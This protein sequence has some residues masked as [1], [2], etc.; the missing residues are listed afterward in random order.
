MTP[1]VVITG[2]GAVTPLGVGVDAL[3]GRWS[4]GECSVEDGFARC[5]DL[6]LP[7][8]RIAMPNRGASGSTDECPISQTYVLAIRLTEDQLSSR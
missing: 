8:S 2:M 1:G 7:A 6:R 4:E 3:F 5:S